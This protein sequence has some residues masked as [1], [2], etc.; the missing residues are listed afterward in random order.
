VTTFIKPT[1][2][3]IHG[4]HTLAQ[5]YFTSPGILA[6]EMEQIFLARWICVGREDRISSPG[7][8]FVQEIGKESV[9][10]LH[11]RAG[12]YRA[13]H[14]VCRHRGT[15]LCEE[16]TGRFSETIQCPYHAWT[17][18]LDGRLI[19]APS[20]GDIEGFN[21]ADWPLHSVAVASWEGFLFINLSQRPE[22]FED[23]FAPLI[24]RFS[25]FNLPKLAVHRTI[26]Y[27]VKCNWKLLFQN[28]SECYDCGPVHPGL[29]KLTPPTSGENDL[30]EG[31][32]TG[33]A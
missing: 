11:D 10:V 20:T 2:I 31:P 3:P 32:F 9:I 27:D 1:E 15:R 30:T 21:K 6:Q 7:Q 5:E 33:G 19:G 29:S 25:R 28:Y 26:D 13:Y 4:A 22:P 17:Y 24:G 23:A 12:G 8:Y 14:N 18:G 16:H